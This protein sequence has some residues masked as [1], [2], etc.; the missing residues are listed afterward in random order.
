MAVR[1]AADPVTHHADERLLWPVGLP[2]I[3]ARAGR[4]GPWAIAGVCGGLISEFEHDPQGGVN[5]SQFVEPKVGDAFTKT[6]GVYRSSLLDQH[7]RRLARKGHLGAETRR[8][9]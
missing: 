2:G 1:S 3:A 6:G 4:S 5:L 9:R 8:S 7:A